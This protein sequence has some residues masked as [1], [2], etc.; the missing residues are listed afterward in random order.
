[1]LTIV[2]MC[3]AQNPNAELRWLLTRVRLSTGTVV[4]DTRVFQLLAWDSRARI[5]EASLLSSSE[6]SFKT[7]ADLTVSEETEMANVTVKSTGQ[8]PLPA[9]LST[10]AT[11]TPALGQRSSLPGTPGVDPQNACPQ[12]VERFFLPTA[13]SQAPQQAMTWELDIATEELLISGE[14]PRGKP[15]HIPLSSS[16]REAP[17]KKEAQAG[18]GASA[19]S[20]VSSPL[21][22]SSGL[23][24][25]E[26]MSGPPQ[27]PGTAPNTQ[28]GEPSG[29][30]RESAM[31]SA[32][33]QA[34]AHASLS[35]RLSWEEGLKSSDLLTDEHASS[36]KETDTTASAQARTGRCASSSVEVCEDPPVKGSD[37]E[38]RVV[39]EGDAQARKGTEEAMLSGQDKGGIGVEAFDML[40]SLMPP[41]GLHRNIRAQGAWEAVEAGHARGFLLS[42]A[43]PSGLDG[44]SRLHE[45]DDGIHPGS[46]P[47]DAL[48]SADDLTLVERRDREPADNA[49]MTLQVSERGE[50]A[51][52]R[53]EEKKSSTEDA[54]ERSE[55]KKS[56]VEDATERSDEKKSCVEDVPERSDEKKS[57]IEDAPQRS[58]K[59]NYSINSTQG[60]T[61]NVDHSRGRLGSEMRNEWI[62][63]QC[64]ALDAWL[65]PGH[66]RRLKHA[67]LTAWAAIA[68]HRCARAQRIGRWQA[69]LSARGIVFLVLRRWRIFA[70]VSHLRT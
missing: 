65:L 30:L 59:K 41:E 13:P 66:A 1:M 48:M 14:L 52:E 20:Y 2:S 15:A 8:G 60:G 33:A 39:T 43:M 62:R 3:T 35:R 54:T 32:A 63:K 31:S 40:P 58:E 6:S 57:S 45:D 67:A 47:A 37:E 50:D 28:E 38:D 23:R 36:L 51:T 34:D 7:R 61:E 68:G 46:R 9:T 42:P 24:Y 44:Q 16:L 29:G 55:E 27:P 70:Q 5:L 22:V 25:S 64:T 17:S 19:G 12:P 53:S 4:A 49:Y 26:P 56:S 21:R 11:L 10:D 18:Y 69:R